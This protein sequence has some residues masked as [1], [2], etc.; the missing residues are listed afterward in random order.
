M[1]SAPNDGGRYDVADNEQQRS[2]REAAMQW[3]NDALSVN[4]QEKNPGRR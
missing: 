4:A 1:R 3:D 2:I